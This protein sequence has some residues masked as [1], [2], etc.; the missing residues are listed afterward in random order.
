[1]PRTTVVVATRNRSGDLARTLTELSLLEPEPPVV[2]VDNGSTDDTADVAAEFPN[3]RVIQLA[4]NHGA[5][6]RT[7]GVVAARTPYVAFS[8]DDSWWDQGALPEAE[9][10]F[11][12]YP[13]LG[14]LAAHTLV[15]PTDRDDPITSVMATSPLGHPPDAPGPLVLGF[16]ACSAVV[17]RVAYIQ[18]GGF[19]PVLHFGGEEQLLAYDLAAR[20]WDLCYVDSVRAHHHPSGH[21]PPAARRRRVQ[22]RNQLLTSWMRR[23]G[24]FCL[25]EL[26]EAVAAAP[27]DRDTLPALA[28]AVRRLPQAIAR[29]QVLPDHVERQART[30]EGTR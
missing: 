19:S 5:A 12:V 4:H 24:R 29:R 16:L 20:G 1:M 7:V 10:I 8:D 2:V 30:L 25:T 14:L 22:Q 15:G 27:R 23:P 26:A 28:G 13:R 3:V 9:R 11:D 18:A 6:A 21:R 17:R